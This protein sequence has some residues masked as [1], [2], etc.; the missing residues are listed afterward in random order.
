[1]K[2]SL[3]RRRNEHKVSL[4]EVDVL[5]HSR[6]STLSI[7]RGVHMEAEMSFPAELNEDKNESISIDT[8]PKE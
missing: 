7:S 3:R 8:I 2:S 6:Q 1:M 5:I 4:E